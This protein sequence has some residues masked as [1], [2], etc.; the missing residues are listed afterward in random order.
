MQYSKSAL[1]AAAMLIASAVAAP[2]SVE[3]TNQASA[4]KLFKRDDQCTESTFI[5]QSSGG[6][7]L[8]SDC[9][10]IIQRLSGGHTWHLYTEDSPE[11]LASYGTCIFGGTRKSEEGLYVSVG[12]QDIKDLIYDSIAQFSWQGVV[13]AKGTMHCTG[14]SSEGG[15]VEW[16]IYHT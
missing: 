11:T 6:S 3:T 9:Q 4:N 2:T 8:V 14:E 7:P 12:E 13:G 1:A 10:Q 5:N 15:Y 16:G